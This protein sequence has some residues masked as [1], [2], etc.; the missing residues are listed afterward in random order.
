MADKEKLA[1]VEY[2]LV[3]RY[4]EY[5]YLTE[6][7]VIDCCVDHDLDLAEIDAV[8]DRLLKRNIIFK[9]AASDL[10]EDNDDDIYDRSQLD[11]EEVFENIVKEYPSYENL[12]EQIRR[13]L[14][15]QH[16][17]WRALI[18][19]AQ[20][21][22]KYAR[23]RLIMMYLRNV[24]KR[25][26]DFSNTYYC[27]FEECFQNAVLGLMSAIDKYDVTSPDSF[28]SYFQLWL[29]QSMGRGCT[30]NG[31][32]LRYPVH[33]KDKL[34]ATISGLSGEDNV[35]EKLAYEEAKIIDKYGEK[36]E[37]TGVYDELK[38]FFENNYYDELNSICKDQFN[39]NHILPTLPLVDDLAIE[40]DF[41]DF[42]VEKDCANSLKKAV[43]NLLRDRERDVI[44]ARYGLDDD[45]PKTLEEVGNI[46]GVTRERIRQIEGK[47]IK[48]IR[49][50]YR[51]IEELY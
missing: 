40:E 6:D 49:N 4:R 51:L 38:T 46:F 25:A 42:V 45:I 24:L 16:K 28:I 34:M 31:T 22:N 5:G 7:E 3:Q 47:A 30:I 9:D 17:E 2:S 12:V 15:P 14:P 35:L 18:G 8:C 19:E 21:G 32:I 1:S 41:V 50:R 48:K 39:Y 11:Y 13:I 43:D 44:V 33:Y 36:N 23:E 20:N 29:V 37:C 10:I 26:Y 27:D